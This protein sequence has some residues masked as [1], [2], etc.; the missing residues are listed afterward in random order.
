MPVIDRTGD[1]LTA[2]LT[3]EDVLNWVGRIQHVPN[4]SSG[5]T[6]SAVMPAITVFTVFN[7]DSE[8]ADD[9]PFASA[10]RYQITLFSDRAIPNTIASAVDDAIKE[11]GLTRYNLFP[12]FDNDTK[13]EQIVI[14]FEDEP[15]Y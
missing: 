12:L 7:R 9:E 15:I 2:L 5:R 10:L 14:L 11:I 4:I 8:Y 13:T 6:P 1:I 3:S